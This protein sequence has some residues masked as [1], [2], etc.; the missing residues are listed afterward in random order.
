MARQNDMIKDIDGTKETLKLNV[1]ITALW[2]VSN[3]EKTIQMEMILTD[4]KGDKIQA[5]V[6]KRSTG[7]LGVKFH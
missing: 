6:K 7:E 2:C 4:L 3:R 5:I 1:R